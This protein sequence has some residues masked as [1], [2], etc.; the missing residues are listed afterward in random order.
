MNARI[1][2]LLTDIY[3][4]DAGAAAAARL[5]ELMLDHAAR[6]RSRAHSPEN[7]AADAGASH[8]RSKRPIVTGEHTDEHSDPYAELS[9][10]LPL[11]E[12]HCIMI[13]YGDQFQSSASMSAHSATDSATDSV[14]AADSGAGAEPD[15]G[16]ESAPGSPL[17]YLHRFLEENLEEVVTAVHILPFHPDSSD[18]GFSVVDYRQVNPDLGTWEE[19]ERISR[20][21]RLMGDLVLNHC[22]AESDWFLRFKRG[23]DPYTRYFITLDSDT[24][25]SM[26]ERP[27]SHPLLTPVETTHGTQQVWTT[28]SAD[29]V[30]LNFADPIVLL[31]MVDV[32]LGYVE[33]GM[34]IVRLDAILYLWK[35]I[36]HPSIHHPKTHELLQVFR[37]ILEDIA[38]WVL[39]ATETNVPYHESITYFGDGTNEAHL[40]YND[41]LPP[42]T[43]DAML[44]EDTRH[45]QEWAADL[46]PQST[47]TSFFNFTASHDGIGVLPVQGILGQE[48]IDAMLQA[49]RERGGLISYKA[50]PAGEIP[51]EMN[52][53]YLSAVTDPALP[54]EQRAR[55]FLAGEA[56]MLTLAGVPAIYVHSLIGSE[57]W[58]EGVARTGRKRS[59]NREKLDYDRVVDDLLDESSLR[60]QVFEG[61]RRMLE[62]RI[63]EPAFHPSS[64][65]RIVATP[66][67]VFCVVRGGAPPVVCVTNLS[68]D[69]VEV[70]VD[71]REAGV[72]ETKS[73]R[74][75]VSGDT[76]YPHWDGPT[77]ISFEL[78]G[79]EIMWLRPL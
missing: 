55:M 62:A 63:N 60:H 51:Y 43:L 18:D 31:E 21:Y 42:L 13:T 50:T 22:S 30:D 27:R 44:R 47:H 69:E 10:G 35:E 79:Y 77:R 74:D 68:G 46:P 28:F 61:Y 64:A 23:E 9:A 32:L 25:L 76:F 52:I 59:I 53:N 49:V 78:Q 56:V 20:D 11:S 67:Q 24:D 29:Q 4:K 54:P 5:N 45:L 17:A 37:A 3:G 12:S 39:I 19:V 7:E 1:H 26:V 2:E 71:V 36:G 34:R 33:R 72:G 48:E 73:F 57:N 66:H 38:P 14:V 41:S 70:H 6:I 8:A 58:T 40:I 65:Q 75:L 15:G 16:R